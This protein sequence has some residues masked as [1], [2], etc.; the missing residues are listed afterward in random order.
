MDEGEVV[1]VE[2]VALRV[3]VSLA[4]GGI[5]TYKLIIICS[6]SSNHFKFRDNIKFGGNSMICIVK[7]E[8]DYYF[9]MKNAQQE[10]STLAFGYWNIED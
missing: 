10:H 7:A 1:S 6:T 9:A 5:P 3:N 4:V 8:R 2:T